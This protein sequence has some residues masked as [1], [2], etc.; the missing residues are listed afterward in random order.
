MTERIKQSDSDKGKVSN[1]SGTSSSESSSGRGS[2]AEG[3]KINIGGFIP[4]GLI[5]KSSS[6]DQGEITAVQDS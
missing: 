2:G 6:S 1:S 4:A 3:I 5:Q